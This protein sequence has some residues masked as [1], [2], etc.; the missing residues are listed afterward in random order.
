MY[1]IKWV[2]EILLRVLLACFAVCTTASSLA[3]PGTGFVDFNAYPVLTEINTDSVYTVNILANLPNRWQ[4]FS[5]TNFINTDPSKELSDSFNYYTEQN[6]RWAI[7]EDLP[8]DLTVQLNV[9]S[10]SRNERLRLGFRWR[11]NN[12]SALEE[13]F[14]SIHFS[15]SIN[16]HVVQLDY[17][18]A[19]VWQM[20]HVFRKTFPDISDRLYLAGFVDHTFN[21]DLPASFPSSPIVGE[22]QLGCRLV[23]NWHL[24]AE[25]RVNEYRRSNTKNLA[26]GVEYIHR[27]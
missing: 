27:W 10:G 17:E 9:R 3:K 16:F 24:I 6:L 26:I 15:H 4:Y 22:A 8:L 1:G 18:T 19:D 5:L 12:T 13:F 11:L 7:S 2:W 20:E 25:Y 21:Q 23:D 14:K